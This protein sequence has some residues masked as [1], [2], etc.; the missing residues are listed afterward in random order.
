MKQSNNKIIIEFKELFPELSEREIYAITK[1]L[2]NLKWEAAPNKAYKKELKNKLQ[3]L[4][5]LSVE[6]TSNWFTWFQYFWAI[7]TCVFAF[8][9][10]YSIYDIQKTW[11]EPI[12]QTETPSLFQSNIPQS[13]EMDQEIENIFETGREIFETEMLWKEQVSE[14]QQQK[15]PEKKAPQIKQDKNFQ[16]SSSI[17]QDSNDA[18]IIQDSPQMMKSPETAWDMIQDDPKP[19]MMIQESI[20]PL[21]DLSLQDDWNNQIMESRMMLKSE[22]VSLSPI[23]QENLCE[24][25]EGT[26]SPDKNY[27]SFKNN[28]VCKMS[29]IETCDP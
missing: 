26:I 12:K 28:T 29:E 9:L 21:N 17:Q 3:K 15:F 8:S 19:E 27:C 22:S 4:H 25:K 1:G 13:T 14:I 2:E 7:I 23:E 18:E 20:S 16:D 11:F 6:E 5:E 24:S 10:L